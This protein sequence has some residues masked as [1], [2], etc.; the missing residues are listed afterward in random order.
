MTVISWSFIFL[1]TTVVMKTFVPI[2]FFVLLSFIVGYISMLLQHESLM[3]WYPLLE[4]SSLTPPGYVFSVVWGVLYLLM[5]ISAGI[6]WSGHSTSSWMLTL[7]FVV[8]LAFN[9]LWSLCFFY[10]RSPI[11]GFA[12][13]V[14]LF[15]L[16]MLY[17]AGCYTQNKFA[18]I[19]NIPYLMWLLF[20]GYLNVYVAMNN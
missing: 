7:L 13:L 14:V 1:L 2:V 6:V 9:L 11:L 18:A 8:Q 10:F 15:M 4:K 5:G 3:N 17:V 16:V 19:I 12:V 20:A